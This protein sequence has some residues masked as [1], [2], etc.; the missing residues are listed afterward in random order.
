MEYLDNFDRRLSSFVWASGWT[1]LIAICFNFLMFLWFS[2]LAGGW[3]EHLYIFSIFPINE[4][5]EYFLKVKLTTAIVGLVFI[6]SYLW[7]KKYRSIMKIS[8]DK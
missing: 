7:R 4:A 8:F 6:A 3:L 1:F 5:A 2:L